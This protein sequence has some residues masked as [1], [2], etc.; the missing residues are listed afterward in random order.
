MMTAQE[1]FEREGYIV[2]WSTVRRVPGE[3]VEEAQ[4]EVVLQKGTKVVIIGEA[5]VEEAKRFAI[6]STG[7]YTP[8]PRWKFHY[9][10]IAE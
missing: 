2:M 5:T 1:I 7:R 10:A 9:R 4:G 8:K 3:V 6:L